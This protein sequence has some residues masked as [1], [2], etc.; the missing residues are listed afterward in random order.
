MT[1]LSAV[2]DQ[3]PELAPLLDLRQV[4]DFDETRFTGRAVLVV[5]AATR[6]H[7]EEQE[8]TE[9]LSARHSY[10]PGVARLD[11]ASPPIR[12]TAP[13]TTRINGQPWEKM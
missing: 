9:D 3:N 5:A 2:G 4:A 6:G 7:E 10:S 8:Q 12:I 13:T 1:G 11:L